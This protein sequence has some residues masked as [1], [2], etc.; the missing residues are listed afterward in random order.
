MRTYHTIY[1]ITH[2]RSIHGFKVS[3][4]LV[5][6]LSNAGYVVMSLVFM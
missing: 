2:S 4:R 1:H 3:S 6:R 5:F